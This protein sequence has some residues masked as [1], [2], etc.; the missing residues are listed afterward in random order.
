MSIKKKDKKSDFLLFF[1]Q[2]IAIKNPILS[3]QR[4]PC[5]SFS[6]QIPQIKKSQ[7][8]TRSIRRVEE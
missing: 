8:N 6:S 3:R 7:F 2:K 1:F 5:S 4:S